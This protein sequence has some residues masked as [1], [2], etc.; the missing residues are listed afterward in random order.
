MASHL[1]A[2]GKL[3]DLGTRLDALIT[4]I[5][6]K[7]EDQIALCP[8]SVQVHRRYAQFL[9]EVRGHDVILQIA[10]GYVY[11]KFWNVLSN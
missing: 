1:P 3:T 4:E 5:Q 10:C 9:I 7:F 11:F 6:S 8:N 2:V